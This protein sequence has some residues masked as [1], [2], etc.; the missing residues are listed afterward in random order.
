MQLVRRNSMR[1]SQPPPLFP[2]SA[3]PPPSLWYP[4]LVLLSCGCLSPP[5]PALVPA[6]EPDSRDSSRPVDQLLGPIGAVPFEASPEMVCPF[7]VR[8]PTPL[9]VIGWVFSCSPAAFGGKTQRKRDRPRGSA[10]PGCS[11]ARA[12]A[13]TKPTLARR[14]IEPRQHE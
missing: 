8:P 1:I 5:K 12:R 3:A 7:A 4:C 2:P 14:R 10:R 11:P 9:F 13:Q 6:A